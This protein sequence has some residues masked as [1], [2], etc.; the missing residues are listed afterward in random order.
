MNAMVDDVTR[1]E[2]NHDA[3]QLAKLI[4]PP[5]MDVRARLIQGI[6][7]LLLVVVI[8]LLQHLLFDFVDSHFKN[9]PYLHEALHLYAIVS[10]VPIILFILFLTVWLERKNKPLIYLHGEKVLESLRQIKETAKISQERSAELEQ[11]LATKNNE[12]QCVLEHLLDNAEQLRNIA[13]IS[14]DLLWTE[15]I[16]GKL[17]HLSSSV[18]QLTGYHAHDLLGRL[19]IDLI[20]EDER[21]AFTTYTQ[22]VLHR[23]KVIPNFE[24]RLTRQDGTTIEVAVSAISLRDE[25]NQVIGL[26]GTLSLVTRYKQTERA[27]RANQ[28]MLFDEKK[29]EDS[30]GF[31]NVTVAM[32]ELLQA[33]LQGITDETE[34]AA[35]QITQYAQNLDEKMNALLAFMNQANTQFSDMGKNSQKM[36]DEDKGSIEMLQQFILD[37]DTRREEGHKKVTLAM[38]KVRNLRHLVQIVMEIGERTNTLALNASIV[39]ARAGEHGHKFAIVAQEV[40]KL[41]EQSRS[42]ATQIDQGIATAVTTVESVL[43]DRL[44]SAENTREDSMLKEAASR[45]ASLGVHYGQ[46]LEFNESTMTEVNKSNDAMSS[47]ILA[48]LMGIQ[49][50]DITRQRIEQVVR[51]MQRRKEYAETLMERLTN[52]G[53]DIPIQTMTVQTMFPDYV[54][55]QQRDIHLQQTGQ[56]AGQQAGQQPS[57]DEELDDIELF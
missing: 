17:V 9:H 25:K 51:A 55:S 4:A 46:L 49:F 41:S 48:L 16:H 40:R 13:E 26:T 57:Q 18:R 56:Q 31:L 37:T 42:A 28:H 47:E 12:L 33:Q 50:Q 44:D 32:D 54:M 20:V 35:L 7:V 24:T 36:I 1:P 34:K 6:R 3:K 2:A 27:L 10:V 39:A 11:Q 8:V 45:M 43:S 14:G 30:S 23:S 21:D 38:D 22:Q 15:D 19:F 53:S 29:S 5:K 52:P